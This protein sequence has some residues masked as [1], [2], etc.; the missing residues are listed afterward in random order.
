M[1]FIESVVVTA[2]LQSWSP[3]WY[4][5]INILRSIFES[6]TLLPA[7]YLQS[8]LPETHYEGAFSLLRQSPKYMVLIWPLGAVLERYLARRYA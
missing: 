6:L 4:T 3:V 8:H 7:T 2:S 1:V 5:A